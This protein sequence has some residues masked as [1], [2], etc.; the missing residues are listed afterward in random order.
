M[1]WNR[2]AHGAVFLLNAPY[3]PDRIWDR[4]PVEMQRR[5]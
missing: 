2:I 3:G 5:S 4:L 1:C